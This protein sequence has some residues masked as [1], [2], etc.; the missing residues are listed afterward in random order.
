[1]GAVYK[2]FHLELES[3]FAIKTMLPGQVGHE[4]IQRF[5]REARLSSQL[6]HPNIVRVYDVGIE[7]EQH[8]IVMEYI[9][10]SICLHTPVDNTLNRFRVG[11]VCLVGDGVAPFHVDDVNGFPGCFDIDVGSQHSGP[12]PGKQNRNRL[13][14]TPS[15]SLG[16]GKYKR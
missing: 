2:A 10:P 14:I 1:M 6:K 15:R 4:I 3:H 13:S 16:I 5:I 7:K 9:D 12:F 11:H 8:Y